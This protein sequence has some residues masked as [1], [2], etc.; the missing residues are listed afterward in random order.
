MSVWEILADFESGIDVSDPRG[1]PHGATVLDYG[2][3]T[4]VLV[5]STLPGR[6]VKRISGFAD[7]TEAA[8]YADSIRRYIRLLEERGVSVARTDVFTVTAKTSVAYLVQP[9]LD[10]RRIGN[11]LLA[12]ADGR[13]LENIMEKILDSIASL[14]RANEK[15]PDGLEVAA[16][17]QISNWYFPDDEAS[18][19]L[20]DVGTPV[21][22]INGEIRV[23]P[24]FIYRSFPRP[25]RWVLMRIKIV[26]D[27]YR[28]Y[29]DLR[30]TITDMLG[31]F[32][33]ERAAHRLAEGVDIVNRWIARQP[34]SEKI[35]PFTER[36]IRRYYRNDAALLDLSL[37][38][39]RVT[40]FIS[41]R[42]LGRH[43]DYILPGKIERG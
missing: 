35:A 36:E 7:E 28:D 6:V 1:G 14:M 10:K 17:A 9:L 43:Y 25:V 11:S 15:D 5:L 24:G 29:F 30:L 40:R 32:I 8:D 39:R 13:E 34:Q 3:L 37:K 19:L 20:L 4:V 18:P 2:E 22:R 16:D 27:Y 41:V 23:N 26:E 12:G 42:L 31:N 21:I 33:K 38:A